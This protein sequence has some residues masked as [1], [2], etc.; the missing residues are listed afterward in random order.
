MHSHVVNEAVWKDSGMRS[1][2]SAVS[3]NQGW[4]VIDVDHVSVR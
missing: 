3:G 2:W 1:C 4:R